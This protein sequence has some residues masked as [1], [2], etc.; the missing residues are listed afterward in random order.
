[1]Y[2]ILVQILEQL[3]CNGEN[4][5]EAQWWFAV[6]IN[7]IKWFKRA[8][9]ALFVIN[10]HICLPVLCCRL[11]TNRDRWDQPGQEKHGLLPDRSSSRSNPYILLKEGIQHPILIKCDGFGKCFPGF[12]PHF[13]VYPYLL[14]SLPYT[15]YITSQE[16]DQHYI[17]L[18]L[19]ED[20]QISPTLICS[21]LI[22]YNLK[23][24]L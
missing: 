5:G 17:R 13:T 11:C 23:Q 2:Q 9:F 24:I 20:V 1:M 19:Q 18:V 12:F 7:F 22:S 15:P 16:N 4:Y 6:L 8:L 3:S 10:A 21:S 14:C